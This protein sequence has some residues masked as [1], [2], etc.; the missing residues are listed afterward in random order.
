MKDGEVAKLKEGFSRFSE[1]RTQQ[2]PSE[3][4]LFFHSEYVS[5]FRF[6]F[7]LHPKNL[8]QMLHPYHGYLCHIRGRSYSFQEL[9][10]IY[11]R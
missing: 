7:P 4:L 5:S 8:M 6:S 11:E 9:M 3:K 1:R 10:T 2:V